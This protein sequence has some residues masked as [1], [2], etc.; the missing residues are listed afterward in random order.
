MMPD[1]TTMAHP[2]RHWGV[3]I[4]PPRVSHGC[5]IMAC[6]CRMSRKPFVE[7]K[8]DATTPCDTDATTSEAL[9]HRTGQK[10]ATKSDM[11]PRFDATLLGLSHLTRH[12]G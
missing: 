3:Y 11:I 10:I 9:S 4:Y 5:R 12:T 7:K 2:K 6:D 8:G 1:T